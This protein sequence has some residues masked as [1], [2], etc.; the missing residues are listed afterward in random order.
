M[1]AL[2]KV[3]ITVAKTAFSILSAVLLMR[4]ARNVGAALVGSRAH[5]WVKSKGWSDCFA[6]LFG[7][8]VGI[9]LLFSATVVAEIPIVFVGLVVF[10]NI[11]EIV[12]RTKSKMEIP[13]PM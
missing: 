11:S 3:I 6:I 2:L 8:L 9:G 12:K 10:G 5:E 4:F 1:K 13:C 7:G